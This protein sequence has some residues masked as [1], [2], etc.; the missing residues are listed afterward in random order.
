MPSCH[1]CLEYHEIYS[2]S[3]AVALLKLRCNLPSCRAQFWCVPPECAAA[4]RSWRLSHWWC[5]R[6]SPPA[7]SSW[8]PPAMRPD[9]S[10]PAARGTQTRPS[11]CLSKQ[12]IAK[13]TSSEAHFTMMILL[14]IIAETSSCKT[15][16][17]KGTL[18][19]SNMCKLLEVCD[20]TL[21]GLHFLSHIGECTSTVAAFLAQYMGRFHI[22]SSLLPM[23][24]F[25]KHSC[26][27]LIFHLKVKGHH[28][29]IRQTS[30]QSFPAAVEAEDSIR[31]RE[32][33][34]EFPCLWTRAKYR[35]SIIQCC[36]DTNIWQFK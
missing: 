30:I 27:C 17:F 34:L 29:A 4:V 3:N 1:C 18:K 24:L 5:C 6:R 28:C 35:V 22:I 11:A 21:M 2:S 20:L 25:Y 7:G 26:L 13:W 19:V 15:F 10:R 12:T 31:Q 16:S 9:S 14:S 36:C 23:P 8:L 32:L 33:L